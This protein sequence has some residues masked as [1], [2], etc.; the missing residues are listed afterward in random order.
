MAIAHIVSSVTSED[1]RN[2]SIQTAEM[3][4]LVTAIQFNMIA[5]QN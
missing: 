5:I 1:L 3:E 2:V 4:K